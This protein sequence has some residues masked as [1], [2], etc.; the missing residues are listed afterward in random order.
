MAHRES[1]QKAEAY[2]KLLQDAINSEDQDDDEV[3]NIAS[4]VLNFMPDDKDVLLCRAVGYIKTSPPQF[5]NALADLE[6]VPNT[7]FEKCL[8][9]Y[10][11]RKYED[12]LKF[13]QQLP[14]DKR[15]ES[16]FRLLEEQILLSLDASA[17]LTKF[18]STVDLSK[19][20]PNEMKNITCGYY[21]TQDIE[22]SLQY[23]SQTPK[24][25]KGCL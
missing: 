18:Y 20:T 25:K 4:Q 1:E 13:I 12:A 3:I 5:Q 6:T 24:P 17:E 10:G 15:K 7:D 2:I 16:R 14:A 8:C 21:I 19:A 11:L 22:K 23:L 9:Y